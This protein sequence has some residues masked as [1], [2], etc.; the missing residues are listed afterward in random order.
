MDSQTT[1]KESLQVEKQQ[2]GVQKSECK[3]MQI[4]SFTNHEFISLIK[5]SGL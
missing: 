5:A 3:T 2:L 4:S 1:L